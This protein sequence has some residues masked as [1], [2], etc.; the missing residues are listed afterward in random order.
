MARRLVGN[1]VCVHKD[2]IYFT[3][4]GL[5]II[6]R[7]S[8][9]THEMEYIFGPEGEAFTGY[10]PWGDICI[11][12]NSLVLV[13][14]TSKDVWLYDL[15]KREWKGILSSEDLQL[16]KTNRFAGVQI[17]GDILFLIGHTYPNI[18]CLN[19]KTSVNEGE[20][21]VNSGTSPCEI[22]FF[23][24]SMVKKGNTIYVA[25]ELT[26]NIIKYDMRTYNYEWIS[27]G[28]TGRR[29]RGITYDGESFWI[30]PSSSDDTLIQWNENN[31][32]ILEH[33]F[34]HKMTN[35][36]GGAIG[37][38]R[39]YLYGPIEEALI[40]DLKNNCFYQSDRNIRFARNI[41]NTLLMWDKDGKFI[42]DT[43]EGRLEMDT[44]IEDSKIMEYQ[45]THSE[46]IRKSLSKEIINETNYYGLSDWLQVF[47]L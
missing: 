36:W 22:C 41:D 21:T 38:G 27:I 19:L 24:Q 31:G 34:T 1:S 20:D 6:C 45:K 40:F 29:N 14:Y 42:I 12:H 39:L 30:I 32:K 8:L 15:D 16:Q 25:N 4:Y 33:T 46:S 17:L 7:V 18:F 23:A 13:P 43:N 9:N 2:N 10:M 37:K 35:I 47:N 3:V 44:I 26:Y 11:W 28:N 5:N